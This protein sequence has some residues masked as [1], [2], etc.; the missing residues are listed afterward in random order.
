MKS[1][2]KQAWTISKLLN[3]WV[4]IS[5]LKNKE[6]EIENILNYNFWCQYSIPFLVNFTKLCSPSKKMPPHS[7]WQKNCHSNS[8]TKLKPNL[9]ADIHQMLFDVCQI[10]APKNLLILSAKKRRDHIC[11]FNWP[12]VNH[13]FILEGEQTLN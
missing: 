7:F 12:L 8:P 4:R 9:C 11:W 2:S 3:E 6:N 13:Q 10:C 1:E 5:L